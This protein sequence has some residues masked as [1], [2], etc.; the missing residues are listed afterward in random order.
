MN[1]RSASSFGCVVVLATL[2]ACSSTSTSNAT[3]A[4][5]TQSEAGGSDAGDDNLIDAYW[6]PTAS[7][8]PSCT[9]LS[10]CTTCVPKPQDD[11]AR[12]S[13]TK[14]FAGSGPP[15]LACST[16]AGAPAK[17]GTSKTVNMGGTARIFAHGNDSSNLKIEIWTEQLDASGHQTGQKG[18]LVTTTQTG[19]SCDAAHGGISETVMQ[20]T[21]PTTR[22]LCPWTTTDSSVPT[23]VPLI[24]HTY[25][26][27]ATAGWFDLYEFNV[28]AFNSTLASVDGGTPSAVQDVRAL[29]SD[30]YA[31]IL[32]AAYAKPP[33]PGQGAIAGEVHDCGD[34]RL[35]NATVGI[36]P[37]ASLGLVYMSDD[38]DNPLPDTSRTATGQLGLYAIGG[39]KPGTYSVAA[40]GQ[41]AGTT[42]GLDSYLV[43]SFA[44]AVT[45]ITFRGVRPWQVP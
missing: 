36:T 42:S 35:S 19:A 1:L 33:T 32:E 13:G 20:G 30:D 31:S 27:T 28:V 4:G 8:A 14:E 6:C 5:T 11:L 40:A 43:S 12:T 29:S 39:L 44:D 9:K 22:W 16:S 3:D 15:Q 37:A 17:P 41:L 26:A 25:S 7:A 45:V 10:V 18:T 24:T 38:E 21:S 23:E 2:G 34:V